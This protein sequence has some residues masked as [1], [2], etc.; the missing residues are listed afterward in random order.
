MRGNEVDKLN[1]EK[2][3]KWGIIA[4]GWISISFTEGMKQVGNAEIVAVASRDISRAEE[5]AKKHNIKKAYGSYEEIVKDEEVDAIY[6]ATPHPYH[7][8][9]SIMCLQ[10]SKAVLCEKPAALNSSELQEV[11]QTAERHNTFYMEAMWTRFLPAMREVKAMVEKGVIG[12]VKLLKADFSFRAPWEPEGRI[13]NRNLAGGGLLD[14][15]VYVIS[16]AKHII[17][18]VPS[19][20]TSH[21]HIGNTGV[22]EQGAAI[23]GYDDGKM[24]ILNFGVR[25]E[26]DHFAH[27]YGTEGYIKLPQF[28]GSR[29]IH[30]VK[31]GE[32]KVI[33]PDFIG[34]GYNYE[35]E[36]VNRCLREGKLQSDIMTWE[37]SQGVM[38]M[39]DTLRNQWNLKYP[40]EL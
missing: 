9:L 14:V 40:S 23:L 18:E 16:F 20:I 31:D 7:K 25:T 22:D 8:E 10:H 6:I 5:F 33:E 17:E 29:K 38:K 15:G 3:I 34:N 28:W 1:C 35:I 26:T 19:T 37:F 32:E 36:E 2:K 30:L 13:L 11:I 21:A 39:M 27:I 24:A 12:E 4:P